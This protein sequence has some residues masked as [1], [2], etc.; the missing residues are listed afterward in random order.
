MDR[1]TVKEVFDLSM[2]AETEAAK[3]YAM[4]ADIFG[5]RQ[6]VAAFFR[7][8]S[9]EEHHH[10]DWIKKMREKVSAEALGEPAPSKAAELIHTFLKFKAEDAIKGIASLDDAYKMA[11]RL[12]F[13]E[14][15][16]LHELIIDMF[17]KGENRP[18]IMKP[19]NEHFD[20]IRSFPARFG[21]SVVR[22][23]V[24]PRPLRS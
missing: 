16:K 8:M 10:L 24:L 4:L 23:N 13:S 20:K 5:E 11:V 19:L 17:E 6:D 1:L 3:F 21:D 7:Q 12:E 2:A 18:S 9:N 14:T 15:G 22:A